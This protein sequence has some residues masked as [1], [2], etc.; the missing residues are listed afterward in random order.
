[1]NDV[2]KNINRHDPTHITM[3]RGVHELRD[4][5]FDLPTISEDLH[6]EMHEL[7]DGF[8]MSRIGIRTLISHY[9]S[10]RFMF[11]FLRMR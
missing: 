3:A 1:M 5:R 10:L 4:R 2:Y 6:K 11:I 9:L 7:L 8:Y